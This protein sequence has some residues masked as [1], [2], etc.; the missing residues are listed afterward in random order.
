MWFKFKKYNYTPSFEFKTTSRIKHLKNTYEELILKYINNKNDLSKEE[1]NTLFIGIQEIATYIKN[2]ILYQL[3][4]DYQSKSSLSKKVEVL[5]YKA[6]QQYNGIDEFQRFIEDELFTLAE[7]AIFESIGLCDGNK[8]T[9]TES[10]SNMILFFKN[11]LFYKFLN[12]LEDRVVNFQNISSFLLN[13]ESENILEKEELINDLIKS[14]KL[15]EV[16]DNKLILRIKESLINNKIDEDL[17]PYIE[18]LIEYKEKK[19]DKYTN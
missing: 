14:S 3:L 1:E 18:F 11:K 10:N 13:D 7:D 19:Y 12:F 9:K 16:V 15:F 6:K 4:E 17:I 8:Y 2:G 5:F